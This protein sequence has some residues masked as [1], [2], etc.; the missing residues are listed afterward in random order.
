[1]KIRQNLN[2]DFFHD[3]NTFPMGKVKNN[4]RKEN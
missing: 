2:I 3:D 4:K 1:M